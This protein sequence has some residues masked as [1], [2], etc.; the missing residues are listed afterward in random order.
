MK[1]ATKNLRNCIPRISN[2]SRSQK[3]KILS[4][5]LY[6]D[7]N[8]SLQKKPTSVQEPYH[9]SK[10]P[11][12]IPSK[13]QKHSTTGNEK[14]TEQND[15]FRILALHF[16]MGA[17]GT[18]TRFQTFAPQR[19][20]FCPFQWEHKIKKFLTGHIFLSRILCFSSNLL[21]GVAYLTYPSSKKLQN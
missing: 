10:S 7:Q 3:K 5:I 12:Q 14:E 11:Q 2:R 13:A 15:N 18:R 19:Y 17:R 20:S 4:V 6:V 9:I 16:L 1:I 8:P 21:N